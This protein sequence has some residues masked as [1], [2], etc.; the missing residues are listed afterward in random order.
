M[1]TVGGILL[2]VLAVTL[3]VAVF[4]GTLMMV[5]FAGDNGLPSRSRLI[6]VAFLV[7]LPTLVFAGL[8]LHLGWNLLSS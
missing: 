5:A 1:S 3:V 6:A 2:I 8:F 4:P 7:V